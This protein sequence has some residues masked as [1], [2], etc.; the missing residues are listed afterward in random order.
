MQNGTNSRQIWMLYLYMWIVGSRFSKQSNAT[1]MIQSCVF[2]FVYLTL[3]VDTD[4]CSDRLCLN[5][6]VQRSERSWWSSRN[7]WSSRRTWGCSFFRTSRTSSARSQRS[8]W[9]IR[10]TWRSW[11]S[12][13][14][15]RPG[16]P[17]T[18]SNISECVWAFVCLY[19]IV[20]ELTSEL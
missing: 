19:F 6:F 3:D 11:P 9:S 16:A 12:A 7:V 1:V 20:Y 13:S 4:V 14:W 17:K 2:W 10:A 8:K 15:P 5:V 18:T